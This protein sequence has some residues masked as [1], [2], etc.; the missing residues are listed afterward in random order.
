M[1]RVAELCVR[2][3]V[4]VCVIIV[5]LSVKVGERVDDLFTDLQDGT[6][7]LTLMN[8]LT[9][10]KL[11]GHAQHILSIF[12]VTPPPL[13]PLPSHSHPCTLVQNTFPFPSTSLPPPFPPPPNPPPPTSTAS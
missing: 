13:L 9:G 10:V 3:R 5:S 7:L 12:L 2:V 4:C 6:K 11:V 1:R 8:V